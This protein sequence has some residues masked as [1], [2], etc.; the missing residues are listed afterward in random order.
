MSFEHV[1][2]LLHETIHGLNIKSTGVYVD[3]TLG[4]AG[5]ASKICEKLDSNGTFIG[6]DQDQ[7]ALRVSG[8]R[9]GKYSNKKH[10]VHSNF[11]NIKEVLDELGIPK[12]DGMIMDIGV[13]SYQLDEGSRGFSYMQDA[14]LDMRMDVT[15]DFSASDI[16]NEY[17][18][19][20]LT[21]IIYEYGE[22]KWA[23]RIAN[24]IIKERN[25]KPI[26]TTGE[27][28]EVIKKAIPA[29]ARRDGPHPAKRTFQAIRIEVNN[30]LGILQQTIHDITERLN[31]GGRICI[32]TFHS[33][34][35]RIVKNTFRDLST[36]CKCPPE[37]P[38]CRCNGKASLKVI[39]RKPILPSEN[40]L[41]INPRSRSAKLRIAEKV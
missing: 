19:E 8:E 13:S 38:I 35:D 25:N 6:V 36:A 37:Y 7:E 11:S 15:K 5:H 30:E 16:V 24:F 10:L 32:I 22:E 2:V 33:L 12:I 28:V 29:A 39:T 17:D 31:V 41:E 26:E 14:P 1:S 27:L 4:G 9:L 3:G 40:E 18:E 20:E 21:R 23:K 34:E